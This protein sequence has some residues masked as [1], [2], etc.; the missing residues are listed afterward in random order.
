[1]TQLKPSFVSNAFIP[2]GVSTQKTGRKITR[3]ACLDG[4]GIEGGFY[5]ENV[6]FYEGNKD[7]AFC[8]HKHDFD[9]V[10][11]FFG[12]NT[13]E[14]ID[15]CG[16][17]ELWLDD[18]KHILQKSCLIVMPKGLKHCPLIIRSVDRP[19]FSYFTGAA[20]LYGGERA[21]CVEF[22]WPQSRP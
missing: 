9:E 22:L 20:S 8:S 2:P 1:M 5:T 11:A 4:A 21:S 19:I 13:E 6:W 16:K 10:L 18:E 7:I 14:L 15:L 12:S 3:L 17:T